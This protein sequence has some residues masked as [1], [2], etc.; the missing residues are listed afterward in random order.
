MKEK[1]PICLWLT[2]LSGAG[3]T[4]LGHYLQKEMLRLNI[5]FV[6][7]DGD[8]LRM[9][10]SRDLGFTLTERTENIRRAAELSRLILRSDVNVICCFISPTQE[11]RQLAKSII[12][13]RHFVEVFIDAPMEVCIK[14]DPKGIYTKALQGKI[15]HVSGIDS[16]YEPPELADIYIN[17]ADT[18]INLAVNKLLNET[19]A[20]IKAQS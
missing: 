19:L 3:K 2:G 1:I 15:K 10:L 11:I 14:R 16:P 4:T 17:T 5:E 6:L 9:G 20:L 12:G 8:D 18:S 7:I 13:I